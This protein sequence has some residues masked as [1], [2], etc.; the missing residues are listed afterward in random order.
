MFRLHLHGIRWKIQFETLPQMEQV[1]NHVVPYFG[2]EFELILVKE[3]L[4]CWEEVRPVVRDQL[5]P[6]LELTLHDFDFLISS[7]HVN[8]FSLERTIQFIELIE[9]VRQIRE[10]L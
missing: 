5:G 8:E 10:M 1:R 6:E 3:V 9:N 7:E 4:Q 2:V